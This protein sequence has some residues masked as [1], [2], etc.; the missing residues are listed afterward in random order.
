MLFGRG[1][2]LLLRGVVRC[3][4]QSKITRWNRKKTIT[5][6]MYT[7]LKIQPKNT[8][9]YISM[10]NNSKV[11]KARTSV[12][13]FLTL[14]IFRMYSTYLRASAYIPSRAAAFACCFI[15]SHISAFHVECKHTLN[16]E[17]WCRTE[18]M[19]RPNK[20]RFCAKWK[21]NF[22]QKNNII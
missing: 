16:F 19:Q 18:S 7:L 11:V 6:N 17:N 22:L 9:T 2:H 21:I 14:V 15:N 5:Q 8:I 1:S 3:V 4:Y 13:C 12:S 10:R 20:C